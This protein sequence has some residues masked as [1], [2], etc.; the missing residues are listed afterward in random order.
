MQHLHGELPPVTTIAIA[1]RLEPFRPY[2]LEDPFYPEDIGYMKNLRQQTTV[3]I[4]IGE[5]FVN[6]H[7]YVGLVTDRLI[8]FIRVHIPA[9]GGLTKTRKL[10]SALRVVRGPNRMACA[11]RPLPGR[12][13]SQRAY[14]PGG[15]QF[16]HSG[17]IGHSRRS[18]P[19][20]FSGNARNQEW[21][22]LHQRSAGTRHRHQRERGSQISLLAGGRQFRAAALF[23]WVDNR[24]LDSGLDFPCSITGRS[25]PSLLYCFLAINLAH[26]IACRPRPRE[27]H[28]GSCG[29]R[30][31]SGLPAR[32][33]HEH[34]RDLQLRRLPGA[35]RLGVRARRPDPGECG[36]FHRPDGILAWTQDL[37][38]RT[39]ARLPHA[40]PVFRRSFPVAGP[41]RCRLGHRYRGH[42]SVYLHPD[43]R[44]GL[45]FQYHHRRAHPFLG[46]RLAGLQRGGRLCVCRRSA[47]HQLGSGPE[48]LLHGRRRLVCRV[49][50]CTSVLWRRSAHVS[51]DCVALSGEPDPARAEGFRDLHVSHYVAAEQPGGVLHVAAHVRQLLWGARPSRHPAP[52]HVDSDVQHH[53]ALLHAGRI[54]GNP[55]IAWDPAGYRDGGDA[56]ASGSAVA[57]GAVLRGGAVGQHGDGR[58]LRSGGRGHNRQRPAAAAPQLARSP[59]EESD[60]AAGVYGGRRRR[61]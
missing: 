47:R 30:K 4:A 58:R 10:T 20:G 3:P 57:G 31:K 49:P 25:F 40:S 27:V 8:D 7:D 52:G 17:R 51:R 59:A 56:A 19:R 35:T 42:G 53:H 48:G 36:H 34:R 15:S 18:D 13:R 37:G 29:R 60:P 22:S 26:W 14:G 38:F 1:K 28:R 9:I 46:G 41:A 23:E 2:F 12:A 16:R 11:R 45:R 39:G 50:R 54:R 43:D 55:G 61:T 32:I 24:K 6:E 5:K 21:L 44:R 33:F